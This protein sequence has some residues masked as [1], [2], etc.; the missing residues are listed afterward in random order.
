MQH[1]TLD[2]RTQPDPVERPIRVV[3]AEDA[4]LVREAIELIL[5]SAPEIDVVRAVSDGSSLLAAVDELNP[6]VVITDIRMPPSVSDEGIRVAHTLRETHPEIGVVVLS[7]YAEPRYPL[8]LL[9][10]GSA[11]RAYLLKERVHDRGE[12]VAAIQKV[13]AGESVID[14]KVVEVLVQAR[15]RE[16]SSP[17]AEL[18]PREYEVL[19]EIARGKSNAAIA[20]SLFLTKR[21]V[22]KH[23]NAIFMK[24]NLSNP[25]DVSRRVTATLLFLGS[26]EEE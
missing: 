4:Y 8:A 22:E 6:D 3:I 14:P 20:E 10:G 5:S 21:A 18:T 19:A 15:A 17:L 7:Q 16:D 25:D 23:I 11:R 9:E 1:A 24:L 26:L 12:L 2:S 13:V